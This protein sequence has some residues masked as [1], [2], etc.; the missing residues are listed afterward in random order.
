MDAPSLPGDVDTGLDRVKELE[1][2][3]KKLTHENQ[4]LLT[5]VQEPRSVQKPPTSTFP[6]RVSNGDEDDVIPL[7]GSEGEDDEW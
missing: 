4:K 2:M 1:A 7:S 5:K 6:E 3:V